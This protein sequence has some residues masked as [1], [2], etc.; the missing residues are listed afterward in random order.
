MLVSDWDFI[1]NYSPSDFN[2]PEKL[3]FSVVSALD[4]LTDLVGKKAIILDDYR[5]QDVDNPT[6][7]HLLGKAIDTTWPNVQPEAVWLMATESGLFGG[8]GIYVN[9]KDAVSFHFDTRDKKPDGSLYTWGGIITRPSGNKKIDYTAADVVLDMLPKL[10]WFAVILIGF[11]VWRFLK[12]K[13]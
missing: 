13:K 12:G 9:E 4:R 11:A 7:Q 8:V 3:Q 5:P 10:S 2:Y 6:S 1:K